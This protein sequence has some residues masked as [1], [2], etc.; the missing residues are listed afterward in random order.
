VVFEDTDAGIEAA[1]AAGMTPFDVRA[2]AV[3]SERGGAA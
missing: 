2:T 3:C 1:V